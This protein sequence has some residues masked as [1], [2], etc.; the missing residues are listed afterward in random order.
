MGGCPL[1]GGVKLTDL[2]I[3]LF[4]A[5]WCRPHVVLSG[6]L[7]LFLSSSSHLVSSK[8]NGDS[9]KLHFPK[10]STPEHLSAFFFSPSLPPSR[11]ADRIGA[12]A[13]NVVPLQELMERPGAPWAE[14]K[15]SGV[16]PVDSARFSFFFWGVRVGHSARFSSFLL[17]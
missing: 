13:R 15:K 7:H 14:L 10:P 2:V 12:P 8:E 1:Q 6:S 17:G 3:C 11:T 9:P 4:L 16:C 5:L